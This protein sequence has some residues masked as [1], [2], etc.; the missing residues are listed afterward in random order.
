MYN[1]S[2]TA[3]VAGSSS[4]NLLSNNKFN[5]KNMVGFTYENLTNLKYNKIYAF[6]L[7]PDGKYITVNV[8][9]I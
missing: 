4:R 5:T 2:T 9:Q 8:I 1:V 3:G 7:L 6:E